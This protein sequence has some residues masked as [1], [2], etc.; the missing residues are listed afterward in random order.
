MAKTK[1]HLVKRKRLSRREGKKKGRFPSSSILIRDKEPT[2]FSSQK[3]KK[4]RLGRWKRRH[5]VRRLR[6]KEGCPWGGSQRG[7]G[8]RG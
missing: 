5:E 4:K 6:L 8:S 7:K 1:G 3:F 2:R